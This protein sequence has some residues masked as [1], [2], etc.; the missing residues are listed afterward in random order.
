MLDIFEQ[1]KLYIAD[2]TFSFSFRKDGSKKQEQEIVKLSKRPMIL[3]PDNSFPSEAYRE[4][5][6]K[7]V[8]SD[9]GIKWEYSKT[10]ID[11]KFDEVK[12]SSNLTYYFETD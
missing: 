6:I 2:V 12:F 7:R 11:V 8:M 3:M 4:A 1:P 9:S 5:Y 10:K